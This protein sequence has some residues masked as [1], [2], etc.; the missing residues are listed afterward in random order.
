M[1]TFNYP[2]FSFV[3][4]SYDVS[5]IIYLH[6]ITTFVKK[7]G[8]VINPI[9]GMGGAVGLKGTNGEE[10]LMEAIKRGAKPSSPDKAAITLK[11]LVDLDD[12]DVQI[13][14][15][16]DDM[17][18][19]SLKKVNFKRY[20]IVYRSPS[21][22][23]PQDTKDACKRF[24]KEKVALILF[25]GGDGTAKDICEI[26]DQKIPIIGIP[27][28]VKMHSAVFAVNPKKAA[29]VVI[30]FL[31]GHLSIREAEVMDIDEE[32][33][34]KGIWNIKLFGYARTPYE[35]AL[36]SGRKFLFERE[37]ENISKE[38]IARYFV[39]LME[40][41]VV[42]ILGAGTTVKEIG[43]LLNIKKTLLG[44]DVIKNKNI[45][46]RDA[47]ERTLLSILE[48]EEKAKVV[49]SPIGAQGFIF[50]RGNQQISAEVIKKIGTQNISILA[51][52]FKLNQTPILRVDTG[53]ET[54][55]M[56]LRGF[57]RIISGYHRMTVKKV[58]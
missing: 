25:C 26:V 51:T 13:L 44:V 14:T 19:N 20:R 5:K 7:I 41:D 42:Y 31:Q 35:P 33:Y 36:I 55:D 58:E 47:N 27:A 18:E 38:N 52:Q 11:Y 16:S 30:E 10:V 32:K 28:G 37:E 49:I 48:K 17:G 54:L 6:P 45:L 1:G 8:L 43:D 23:S 57:K 39:E 3:F 56:E 15:C 29:Y 46:V 50:G 12:G 4:A 2:V 21:K 9:A 53:D 22:T 34:R 40:K 24:L